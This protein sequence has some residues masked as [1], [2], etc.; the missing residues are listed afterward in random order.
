MSVITISVRHIIPPPPIPWIDRLIRMTVK[1]LAVAAATAPIRKSVSEKKIKGL[2][3]K[4]CEK[5]PRTGW[6]IVDV[7]RNEVPDQK[8]SIADPPRT[9]AMI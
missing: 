5:D 9:L 1:L 6:K 2:R 4:M 8:A 7:R 3:P